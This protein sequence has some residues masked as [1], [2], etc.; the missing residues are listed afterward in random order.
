[1]NTL[2]KLIK[3]Y[4][5]NNDIENNVTSLQDYRDKKERSETIYILPDN[6]SWGLQEPIA[7]DLTMDEL[8]QLLLNPDLIWKLLED[9]FD[10]D[11][12]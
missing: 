9:D 4:T 12:M 7:A 10:D 3:L 8:H 2:K 11:D 6:G 1:M 5:E